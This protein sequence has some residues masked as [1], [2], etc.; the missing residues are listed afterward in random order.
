MRLLTSGLVKVCVRWPR[1]ARRHPPGAGIR[2]PSQFRTSES[3]HPGRTLP[4][5]VSRSFECMPNELLFVIRHLFRTKFVRELVDLAGEA[6]R[7]FVTVV[8]RRAGVAADVKRFVDGH[9]KRNLSWPSLSAAQSAP[10]RDILWRSDRGSSSE[11]I[12]PG[13][14]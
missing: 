7:K 12:S 2:K 3:R 5:L 1:C 6:E 4:C 14:L 10:S 11:R 13:A 9:K 8:H